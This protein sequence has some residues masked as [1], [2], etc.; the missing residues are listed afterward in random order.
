MSWLATAFGLILFILNLPFAL[1]AFG[2]AAIRFDRL[3]A[4]I[5]TTGGALIGITGFTGGFN[6]GTSP[7][8]FRGR[9]AHAIRARL[10]QEAV[11]RP[12]KQDTR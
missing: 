12:T 7:S 1:L 4:T 2:P 10:R 11:F 6:L 3:T 8:W 5:E 9:R